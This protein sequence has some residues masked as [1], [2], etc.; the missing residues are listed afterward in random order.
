MKKQHENKYLSV[1]SH[2]AVYELSLAAQILKQVCD[3]LDKEVDEANDDS[4]DL[5]LVLKK[6][7]NQ[8]SLSVQEN[9]DALLSFRTMLKS[10]VEELKEIYRLARKKVG[11]LE[12]VLSET[13][14]QAIDVLETFPDQPFVGTMQQ[15]KTQKNPPSVQVSFETKDKAYSNIVP[16]EFVEMFELD[17]RY[18]KT[19]TVY[20]LNLKAIGDDI[21]NGVALPWAETKQ[22]KRLTT[23]LKG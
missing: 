19:E 10:K 3:D 5:S 15:L 2:D 17:E 7:F 6:H 9:V 11:D 13:D 18:Y 21:K 22:G 12:A 23:K 4:V 14:K 1:I 16:K 8:A 20:S